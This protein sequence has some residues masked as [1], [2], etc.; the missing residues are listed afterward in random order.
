MDHRTRR[1]AGAMH[2]DCTPAPF[3]LAAPTLL[4]SRPTATQW[5]FLLPASIGRL[6]AKL[7]N[8]AMNGGLHATY[9]LSDFE[10][11][12]VLL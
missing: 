3:S 10:L 7:L 5:L 4:Q 12:L 11:F 1:R 6:V 9:G 8:A 2:S